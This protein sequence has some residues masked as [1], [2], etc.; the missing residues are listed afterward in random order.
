M[1]PNNKRCMKNPYPPRSLAVTGPTCLRFCVEEILCALKHAYV[2][3]YGAFGTSTSLHPCTRC[4][5][6]ITG[7]NFTGNMADDGG[8]LY[9]EGAGKASCSG[10]SV[11]RSKGVDGGA[12]CA[13][14]G[15]S[16]EWECNLVAN[17]ALSGSAM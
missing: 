15:A 4:V 8:F 11:V 6:Q 10:A 7:G 5:H 13:V 2:P 12:L 3:V 9:K 1:V 16:L 17:S 14:D